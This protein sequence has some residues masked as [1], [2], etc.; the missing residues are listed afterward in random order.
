MLGI[1]LLNYFRQYRTAYCLTNICPSYG[2][3]SRQI[4][5]A[6]S[7]VKWFDALDIQQYTENWMSPW[8][9]LCRNLTV[10]KDVVMTTYCAAS[11]ENLTTHGF[12]CTRHNCKQLFRI[13]LLLAIWR[14]LFTNE[15]ILRLHG[16]YKAV[17]NVSLVRWD[18]HMDW[19][20]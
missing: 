3:S 8:C 2:V 19:P 18:I 14:D 1:G 11:E 13:S 15:E 12:Q 5:N 6:I 17:L 20:K 16:N 10:P 9:E 7:I 4:D